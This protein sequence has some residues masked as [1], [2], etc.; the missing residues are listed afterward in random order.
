MRLEL[1]DKDNIF[2]PMVLLKIEVSIIDEEKKFQRK[3]QIEN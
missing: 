3:L 2:N 1:W